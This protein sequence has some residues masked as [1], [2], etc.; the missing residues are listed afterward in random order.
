MRDVT[1]RYGRRV[2]VDGV[3]VTVTPG[4]WTALIGPNGAGKTSLLH[5]LTGVVPC[6]GTLAVGEDD[7]AALRPRERARMVALVPQRPVIPAA[8][9]VADYVLLGRTAHLP[10]L[11]LEGADDRR[12]AAETLERLDLRDLSRRRVSTL[13]GGEQQRVVL[14]RALAQQTPVLL[15][16][17]PT[18]ALDIGH[19]QQVLELVD[20]L[21]RECLLTVFAAMHDLT[22]AAQYAE[23]LVLLDRGRS[24]ATGAPREVLTVDR[25]ATHFGADVHVLDLPDGGLALVPARTRR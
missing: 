15:L 20:E 22:L 19:R 11:G 6:E 24:A 25:V 23:H 9:S 1:V 12:I 4:G 2:A 16:D 10:Y 17:E 18:S 8:M 13:S 21:R 14:A 3:S 7:L 5:A